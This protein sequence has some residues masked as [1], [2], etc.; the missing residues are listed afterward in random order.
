MDAWWGID[1]EEEEEGGSGGG[2][3]VRVSPT[4]R[5]SIG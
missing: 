3:K 1:D 5:S 2:G 4:H